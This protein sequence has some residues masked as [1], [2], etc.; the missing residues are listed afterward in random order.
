MDNVATFVCFLGIVGLV[1]G[2]GM[3]ALYTAVR[4]SFKGV[5]EMAENHKERY[6]L[7]TLLVVPFGAGLGGGNLVRLEN[8]DKSSNPLPSS[9]M[10]LYI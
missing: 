6:V 3:I 5:L 1:G 9:K 7:I 8:L 4:E 2:A 10:R